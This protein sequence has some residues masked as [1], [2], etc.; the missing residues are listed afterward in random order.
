[1]TDRTTAKLAGWLAKADACLA[2]NAKSPSGSLELSELGICGR[3]IMYWSDKLKEQDPALYETFKSRVAEAISKS[4]KQINEFY[5]KTTTDSMTR[6]KPGT[7]SYSEDLFSPIYY[8]HNHSMRFMTY[9]GD[10]VEERSVLGYFVA[11]V[12]PAFTGSMDDDKKQLVSD[13]LEEAKRI[14]IAVPDEVQEKFA[15]PS[16]TEMQA[17]YD[18]RALL[19]L[20]FISLERSRKD[21]LPSVRSMSNLSALVL[22]SEALEIYLKFLYDQYSGKQGSTGERNLERRLSIPEYTAHLRQTE[23]FTSTQ[24]SQFDQSYEM[25]TALLRSAEEPTPAKVS[26]FVNAVYFYLRQWLG[27]GFPVKIP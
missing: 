11:S 13:L 20:A 27:W 12:A 4:A 6:H 19:D 14:G 17:K 16:E 8:L 25:V 7:K 2:Q 9:A 24:L 21:S 1:L 26:K 22:S 10:V 23:G 5:R 15:L 18:C 3:W